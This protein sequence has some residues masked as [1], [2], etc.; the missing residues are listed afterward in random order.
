MVF[1]FTSKVILPYIVMIMMHILR[2][3]REITIYYLKSTKKT[4]V[5]SQGTEKSIESHICNEYL[6]MAYDVQALC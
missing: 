5:F 3:G 4:L 1:F 6:L 2:K